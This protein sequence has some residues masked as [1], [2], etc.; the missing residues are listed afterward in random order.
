MAETKSMLSTIADE[1]EQLEGLAQAL[2]ERVTG[3]DLTTEKLAY[4][5]VGRL[6]AISSEIEALDATA[7]AAPALQSEVLNG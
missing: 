6:N 4:L 7:A 3:H 1:L 2:A 5:L